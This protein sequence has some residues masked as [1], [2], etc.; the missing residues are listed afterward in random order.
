VGAAVTDG[1]GD[2]IAEGRNRAYDPF[3]GA[4]RLQRTPIAHAE[5]NAIA[6]LDIDRDLG[7]CTIWSSHQPCSMCDS[8]I[9]FT[10][11]PPAQVLA[12]D[13]SDERAPGPTLGTDVWVVA[14]NVLFLASIAHH[15]GPTG[16][17]FDRHRVAEPE[18]VDCTVALLGSGVL[19]DQEG[20][21]RNLLRDAW[22]ELT[23]AAT[24]REARRCS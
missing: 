2:I 19:E 11:L 23:A 15:Y 7:T 20:S 14:A 4:D 8:A 6:A 3:G 1:A 5:L 16:A 9:A 17:V 22:D 13:P 18:T 21:L 10:G 12:P 24:R